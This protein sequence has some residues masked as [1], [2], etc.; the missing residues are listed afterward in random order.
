MMSLE[1]SDWKDGG[2]R[3]QTEPSS[4]GIHENPVSGNHQAPSHWKN[5]GNKA[6]LSHTYNKG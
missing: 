5:S 1:N 4:W 6:Y 2:A 3:E